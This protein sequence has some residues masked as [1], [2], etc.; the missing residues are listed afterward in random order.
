MR[1]V[2]GMNIDSQMTPE[3]L[4]EDA[5]RLH[6]ET[7]A[8]L[9]DL[10]RRYPH[11]RFILVAELEAPGLGLAAS[12]ASAPEMGVAAYCLMLTNAT[13]GSLAKAVERSKQAQVVGPN[14]AFRPS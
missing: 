1:Y 10:Q 12:S 11:A 9:D 2:S 6:T 7:Q 3:K 5:Q 13:A 14:G 4:G 8:M